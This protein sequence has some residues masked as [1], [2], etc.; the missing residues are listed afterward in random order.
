[1]LKT[2]DRPHAKTR[3]LLTVS[4]FLWLTLGLLGTTSAQAQES[5]DVKPDKLF[6][7]EETLE[8]TMI[9]PWRDLERNERYQD[10]YPAELK[11]TDSTGAAVTLPMT[12]ERRGVK[13]QEVCR[14]PPIKLRFEK[15]VVKGTTFRGQKSLKMVTHCEKSKRFDQYYILEM[16]AYQMYNVLTDVSFRIRPL[17]VTYVESDNGKEVDSRFAFLI[18][19]DSDLAKRNDLNKIK[20]PR[21]RVSQLHPDQTAL[22]SLFQYMIANV[23]WAAL[24]GP[25]PEECCHNVKLLGPEPLGEDDFIL[26]VAYDFDSSGL[27]DA[28]YAA[29]PNGLPINSVTQRLYR[30]YCGHNPNLEPARQLILSKETEILAVIR[31]ES[32]LTSS[33]QKKAIKYLGDFFEIAR[34]QKK[35]D[36]YVIERCRK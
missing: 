33:T 10:A 3:R 24:A 22:F 26:P 8:V 9:A 17:Q 6:S 23:D 29:P 18:E 25:D 32:R 19:D 5:G 36:K 14:Y 21:V 11:Y 12:V 20:V 13:R 2:T 34:A 1:M 35:Y 30:G 27:V 15:E 7:S 4:V 28:K 31:N 16:L